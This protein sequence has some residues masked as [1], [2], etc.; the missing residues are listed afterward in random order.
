LRG[1]ESFTET[2]FQALRRYAPHVDIT[3]FQGGGKSDWRRIVVPNFHRY[4]IPARWLGY[5]KGNLLEKRSFALFLYPLLRGGRYDIVHYNELVMGS[6]LFHLRRCFGGRFKLLYCNG[7]PAPPILYAHR[8]DYAQ[9]LTSPAYQEA[10]EFGIGENRLFLLPYGVDEKKFKP[11]N[12]DIRSR[13]R[14]ELGIPENAKVVLT[15]AALNREHKRIDYA[16]REVSSL[17]DSVWLVAAGQRT[18]E[19]PSLEEEAERILQGRWRFVSWP[20]DRLRM[21]YGAADVFILASLTEGFGL[22]IIEAMM[23][24]LPVIIHNGP[25]FQWISEDTSARIIDMTINGGLSQ[26]LE[27]VLSETHFPNSRGEAIKRFSWRTLVPQYLE[28]YE[29]LMMDN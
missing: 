4:D 6:A 26:I 8:C 9:I 16:I 1:F 3:L 28:M 18:A 13:V 29:K 11:L 17:G 15:V 24:G 27:K 2:L 25:V 7:A 22:V 5:E 12:G 23:S 14:R 21:L 20:H 19:T 10:R